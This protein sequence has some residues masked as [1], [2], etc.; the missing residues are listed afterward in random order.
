MKKLITSSLCAVIMLIIAFSAIACGHSGGN[1]GGLKYNEFPTN[2]DPDKNS[3]EQ[4]DPDDE[5]VDITWFTNYTFYG[6]KAADLIYDRTGVKVKFQSA[7]TNDNQ[8]LSTMIAGDE[9]PDVITIGDLRT[10]VQLGEEGYAYAIDKLAES[11]APSLLNRIS[12]EHKR[13]YS[14]SDGHLYGLASNFYNDADIAEYEDNIGG[15]QFMNYDVIVRK[16]Y[17]N[18]YIAH[19]KAQDVS[20]NQDSITRPAAFLE[21][22]KW[23]KQRYGLKNSNPTVLLAPFNLTATNDCFNYSLSALM[24][25][26][27]VPMEDSEG[28]YLYQY[29]TP[30]FVEVIKFLNELYR[31]NLI[32][33]GNF[34]Y[35]RSDVGSNLL[36]G[37]AFAYIGASQQH[38]SELGIREKEGH[39]NATGITDDEHTYVSIVLTNSRGDAPLLLDYAGRGLY[40]T[41]ITKNC[42]RVDRVI[43]VMDYL[44]SEQG[45]REM[46]YG[47]NEGEYYTYAVKPGEVDPETGKVSTYG[48]MEWTEKAKEALRKNNTSALFD[49]G[50][51]K[52][53]MLTNLMYTKMTSHD[54]YGINWLQTWMEFKNKCAYF[55]YSVSRVPFRY[56]LDVSDQKALND[57]TEIQTD[58][59]SVWIEALPNFIMADSE[60]QVSKLYSAALAKTYDKGARKWVEYRNRCFKAYKQELNIKYAWPKAD[61]EYV[62]PEV[63]LFGG[64]AK[65]MIVCPDWITWA[66]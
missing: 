34:S 10:R 27:C 45:Q 41:M 35:K 52:T 18:A 44:L 63:S 15:H 6:G 28:N 7:M 30:E 61:P 9:L 3:W 23:V 57:Y 40:V 31:A 65:Y 24:E 25:M 54:K 53:H 36:N 1:K 50:I 21:M 12:E 16:D 20:F 33:S 47:K 62:A 56:P 26:F 42:K 51:T 49:M 22:C 11:Y 39:D 4:I 55:D 19:K 64:S 29:D 59:E 32:T 14:G 17:L 13:Y 38:I 43:K 48:R 58:I 37:K 2:Y 46:Y 60:E 8:E 66:K 5:D